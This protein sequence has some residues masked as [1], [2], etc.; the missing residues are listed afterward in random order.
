LTDLSNSV[1]VVL[2]GDVII[3]RVQ[4]DPPAEEM[5]ALHQA[6]ASLAYA[7]I[8]TTPFPL[9]EARQRWAVGGREV[10]VATRGQDLVGF[11]A[12][13]GDHLDGLYVTPTAEGLGI[14]SAL[15]AALPG[16]TRLWVLEESSAGRRFYE[17]RGWRNSGERQEAYGVWDLLYVRGSP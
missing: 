4:G 2:V 17:R 8:F 7:H 15:L 6:C 10:W 16:V 9:D 1:A 14:G 5:A 13:T 3:A 11:A 12:A